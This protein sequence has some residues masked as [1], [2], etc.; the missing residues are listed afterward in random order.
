MVIQRSVTS[1]GRLKISC[2]SNNGFLLQS[3][4]SD[5]R[6]YG[7]KITLIS[8]HEEFAALIEDR[9]FAEVMRET[10]DLAW[11]EAKRLNIQIC[12]GRKIRKRYRY[13]TTDALPTSVWCPA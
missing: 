1:V 5:I 4:A 3:I 2:F 9:Y 10:F 13:F 12:T 6:I 11:E 7:D 8:E